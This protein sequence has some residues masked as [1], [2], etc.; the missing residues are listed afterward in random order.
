M[1]RALAT[2]SECSLSFVR[3]CARMV[4]MA[5]A[6]IISAMA[7]SICCENGRS[8]MAAFMALS[9]RFTMPDE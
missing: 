5:V 4:V 9:K 7:A 2:I 1:V 3:I 6:S 8:S